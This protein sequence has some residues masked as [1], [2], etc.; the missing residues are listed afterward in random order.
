VLHSEVMIYEP[1]NAFWHGRPKRVSDVV[2][3]KPYLIDTGDKMKKV[4][5]VFSGSKMLLMAAT[6]CSAL[7]PLWAQ[8]K[9]KLMDGTQISVELLEQLSSNKSRT[10]QEVRYR[11][12]ENIMGPNK[13]ILIRKGAVATGRVIAAKGAGGLGRKG[14][15]DFTI[16]SVEAVDGTKVSLRSQQNARGK[17]NTGT[18]A[19]VTL[20]VSPLGLFVKGKNAKVEPGTIFETYVN[21]TVEVDVDADDNSTTSTKAS[22]APAANNSS[23]D[24]SDIVPP[25]NAQPATIVLDSGRTETGVV[26]GMRDDQISFVT[27]VGT[28]RVDCDKIT[29]ITMKNGGQPQPLTVNLRSGNKVQGTLISYKAGVFSI[30]TANGVATVKKENLNSMFMATATQELE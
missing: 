5:G 18:M 14:K 26:T 12:R 19:A 3:R 22:K 24:I 30:E 2:Y 27:E 13:E 29:S 21:E 20:L 25:A 15:L 8:D 23:N 28:M 16:E 6:L 11:V 9:V 10:N 7:S 1:P 4:R 17:S